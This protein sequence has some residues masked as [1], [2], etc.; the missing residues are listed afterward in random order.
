[1]GCESVKKKLLLATLRVTLKPASVAGQSRKITACIQTDGP[2][3]SNAGTQPQQISMKGSRNRM[4]NSN[5]IGPIFSR[6]IIDRLAPAGHAAYLTGGCVRD[7]LLGRTPKISTLRLPRSPMNCFELFPGAGQVGAH[8]G[9]VLVREDGEQV[10]VATFRSDLEYATA[11]IP[12]AFSL[13]P[14][15]GRMCCGG[16]SRSTRYCSI[17]QAAR[18]SISSAAAR[19]L[20]PG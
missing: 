15:R 14:I 2:W 18:Y 8:F 7:L 16:I 5:R 20:M 6:T 9:V 4:A 3:S 10:E 13:K 11:A 17:P 1:M 19:I 12:R